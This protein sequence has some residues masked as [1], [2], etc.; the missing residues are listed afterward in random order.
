MS[1]TLSVGIGCTG[2]IDWLNQMWT[3][4]HKNPKLC[5]HVL[6]Q[7]TVDAVRCFCFDLYFVIIGPAFAMT[8]KNLAACLWFFFS[9]ARPHSQ[10]QPNNNINE[11]RQ[12]QRMSSFYACHWSVD[13]S[14]FLSLSMF[15]CLFRLFS[16]A[17]FCM[18]VNLQSNSISISYTNK[19]HLSIVVQWQQQQQKKS[20][21][22][23]I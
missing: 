13:K 5:L 21:I 11:Q 8:E 10:T 4:K 16:N 3:V 6:E 18:L 23:L 9:L 20:S 22:F 1:I 14:F 7:L 2:K 15:V 19:R 12:T 17:Y